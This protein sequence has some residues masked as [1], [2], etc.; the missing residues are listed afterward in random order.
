[1]KISAP[2]IFAGLFALLHALGAIDC[3]AMGGFSG[4]GSLGCL[5]FDAPLYILFKHAGWGD[6]DA[7]L[8]SAAKMWSFGF[9]GTLIYA[10]VGM[11][12]GYLARFSLKVLRS[13]WR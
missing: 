4:D 13:D 1:M 7:I 3:F 10:L 12:F 8:G 11:V 5:M 2:I 9:A 6:V